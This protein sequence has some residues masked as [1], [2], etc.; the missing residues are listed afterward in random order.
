M[1]TTL[2]SIAQIEFGELQ[3]LKNVTVVPLF[4]TTPETLTYS[5]LAEA[6]R[7]GV[8]AV[9]ELDAGGSVPNLKVVNNAGTPV[10][11]L[12]GEELSGAKQNRVLNTS[13]LLGDHSE[14]II[15]VSCTE[16]GRWAYTSEAF[17]E[18]GYVMPRDLRA[19]RAS[20]VSA[21]LD[22][23]QEF[24]SDQSA[25]WGGID[26]M[27]QAADVTSPTGAMSDIFE[28][29]Q[30]ELDGY[31]DAFSS[32]PDQKGLLVFVNG[33]VVGLD[34]ISRTAAYEVLHP[35]LVKSYVMDAL[36]QKAN[37]RRKAA[38][39]DARTFVKETQACSEK[40]YKSAG[41]GWD[42]RF[43]GDKIVGSS[44][45]HNATVVHSAF[46]RAQKATKTGRMANRARRAEYRTRRTV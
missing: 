28:A 43:E 21:S 16:A 9:T 26:R 10:L 46:F 25:V 45:V 15:P 31:L 41:L 8:I 17:T 18:S 23:T 13:V 5:T 44:L 12:D 11:L 32:V 7:D 1:Q 2:D 27:A 36:L 33:A 14:T 22:R 37:G 6:L 4:H 29:K 35:K 24:R 38:L 40:R 39:E 42:Y 30:K 20:T 19:E 3:R 34:V